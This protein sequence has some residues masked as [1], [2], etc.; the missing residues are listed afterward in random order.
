MA[1][2]TSAQIGSAPDAQ[3]G[4]APNAQTGSAPDAQTGSA[5]HEAV[6]LAGLAGILSTALGIAG[7]FVDEMWT[8][9][10][11][12]ATAGQIAGFVDT[13][14]SALLIALLLSTIAVSLWLAFGVGV[15]LL[16]RATAQEE[17]FLAVCFLAGL[18]SF[19][20]LLLTGFTSFWMLVYRA[21]AASDPRLL[22]DLAFGLLAMSGAPTALAL[23]AY[24]A[25]VLREN[26]LPG[27]TA[28]V[29]VAAALANLVLLASLVI[30][31][32]FFSLEGGVIIAIPGALFAWIVA[33]SVIMVRADRSVPAIGG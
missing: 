16:M 13:H 11:T 18:V 12:A 17:S 3:T 10:G 30:R 4:S 8:I 20:T 2:T 29:A 25:Q 15:W 32:G 26:R 5:T 6:R 33:M 14:R 1:I 23:C 28:W 22:Y 19:V 9:P 24:A 27:W 31:S 7:V 21:P